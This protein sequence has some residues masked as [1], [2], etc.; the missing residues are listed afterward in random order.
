MSNTPAYLQNP[1]QTFMFGGEIHFVNQTIFIQ[2]F[3]KN[4]MF[5]HVAFP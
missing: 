4:I 1:Y 3:V 5:V 2:A